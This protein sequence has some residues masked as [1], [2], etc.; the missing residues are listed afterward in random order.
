[1]LRLTLLAPATVEAIL[2][3]RAVAAP[4]L[5]E[6]I[7]G[8]SG[9]VEE[10]TRGEIPASLTASDVADPES[11]HAGRFDHCAVVQFGQD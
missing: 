5:A 7:G 1:V 2:G 6:V 8:V 10:A 11:T 9:G 4:T 3:G